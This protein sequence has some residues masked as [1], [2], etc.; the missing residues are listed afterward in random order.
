MKKTFQTLINAFLQ[1]GRERNFSSL[2]IKT[3]GKTLQ[4]GVRLMVLPIPAR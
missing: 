3:K 4:S 1:A 2:T